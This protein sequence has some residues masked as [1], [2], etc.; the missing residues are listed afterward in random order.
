MVYNKK[1]LWDK[2]EAW[3]KGGQ[4]AE[5]KIDMAGASMQKFQRGIRSSWS[6]DGDNIPREKRALLNITSHMDPN[7]TDTATLRVRWGGKFVKKKET[8]NTS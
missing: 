6:F 7:V 2:V 4:P 3:F 1:A 8:G 5:S